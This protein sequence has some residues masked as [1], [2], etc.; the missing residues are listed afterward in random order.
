MIFIEDSKLPV[1]EGDYLICTLPSGLE[2][3]YLVLDR[4]YFE[5]FASEP[6]HYQ[7][8][9]KK[10]SSIELERGV[11][12]VQN[13]NI[14]TIYR[15]NIATHGNATINNTFNFAAVDQLIEEKGGSDKEELRQMIEE[16]KELLE[17]SEK[18][19]KGSL[20]Q[21]S[22]KIEKTVGSLGELHKW[23]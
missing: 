15:S 18:V 16:I 10:L 8:K 6:A 12:P 4:G 11:A 22:E 23:G 20:A 5:S 2:E 9:V 19:K 21:Y 7:V 17:D 13:F 14:G 3:K 1:E